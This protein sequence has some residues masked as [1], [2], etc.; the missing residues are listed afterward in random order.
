M[1]GALFVYM[2]F[3]LYLSICSIRKYGDIIPSL[4]I[5]LLLPLHIYDKSFL[6]YV[7]YFYL[8][9]REKFPNAENCGL[10]LNIVETFHHKRRKMFI[11]ICMYFS[12]MLIRMK[13]LCGFIKFT[14][15]NVD[16]VENPRTW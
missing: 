15:L 9:Y 10:C 2:K 5:I 8:G 12:T 3:N 7:K 6:L 11:F 4:N 1:K 16:N 13:K 14:S